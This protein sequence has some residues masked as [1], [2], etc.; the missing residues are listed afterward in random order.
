MKESTTA[1]RAQL[2][3]P[4]QQFFIN[5]GRVGLTALPYQSLFEYLVALQKGEVMSYITSDICYNIT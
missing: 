4:I 2:Q 3:N 5:S 1:M